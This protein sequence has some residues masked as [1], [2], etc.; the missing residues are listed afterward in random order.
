LL[1][2][3]ND[4]PQPEISKIAKAK[5]SSLYELNFVINAFYHATGSAL[6]KIVGYVIKP[7]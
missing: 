6:K 2:E 7:T 3:S 5:S 1:K 4:H